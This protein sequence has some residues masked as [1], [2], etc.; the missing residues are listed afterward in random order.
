MAKFNQL[1]KIL[2]ST[3]LLLI[4][5]SP[6]AGVNDT[7]QLDQTPVMEQLSKWQFGDDLSGL[8]SMVTDMRFNPFIADA[9]GKTAYEY[10]VTYSVKPI[11][12]V[13]AKHK[14]KNMYQ[15]YAK[16]ETRYNKSSIISQQHAVIKMVAKGQ[17]KQLKHFISDN[18]EFDFNY[19][20]G[21]KI[22]PL[23]ATTLIKDIDIAAKVFNLLV[24]AGANPNSQPAELNKDTI[25]HAFCATDNY[26]MLLLAISIGYDINLL[27]E[28]GSDVLQYS[29]K[30]N[31]QF[32]E[33]HLLKIITRDE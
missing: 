17:I 22:T 3:C 2:T 11:Q 21:K 1:K 18:K 26:L 7:S 16:E 31:A 5:T 30:N 14:Y 33:A 19:I 15:Q 9:A 24:G 13:L 4:S 27:N 28:S 20:S 25:G 8:N 6:L 10:S 23:L 12:Y 32:C 29:Q